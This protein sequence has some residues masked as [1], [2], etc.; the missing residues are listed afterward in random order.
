MRKLRM[1]T[2]F[3]KNQLAYED[4]LSLVNVIPNKYSFLF[5]TIDGLFVDNIKE[6]VEFSEDNKRDRLFKVLL[7]T[8]SIISVF[9][10]FLSVKIITENQYLRFLQ[11]TNDLLAYLKATL[12]KNGNKV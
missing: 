10:A 8:K 11:Q 9:D 2:L 3:N 1:M 6:I 5:S 4:F 7:N 12:F